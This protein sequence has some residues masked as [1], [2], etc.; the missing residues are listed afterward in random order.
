MNQRRAVICLLFR[1][2]PYTFPPWEFFVGSITLAMMFTVSYDV[3]FHGFTCFHESKK[4]PASKSIFFNR[5][6][7][8]S[9]YNNYIEQEYRH[10]VYT[11]CV[12]WFLLSCFYYIAFFRLFHSR[13][14]SQVIDYPQ[15]IHILLNKNKLRLNGHSPQAKITVR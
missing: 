8:K 12:P 11:A 14:I 9:L 2:L 13:N 10:I 7:A 4:R 3:L 1:R 15:C 6:S 5:P